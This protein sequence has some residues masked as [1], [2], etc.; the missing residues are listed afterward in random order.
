[1]IFWLYSFFLLQSVDLI[2]LYFAVRYQV[3][4][5]TPKCNNVKNGKIVQVT[6]ACR[7]VLNCIS[8]Q[9]V[10]FWITKR[11]R[12]MKRGCV[13]YLVWSCFMTF[14]FSIDIKYVIQLQ[15]L[16]EFCCM[17]E[18]DHALFIACL[19]RYMFRFF[20][21]CFYSLLIES[22]HPNSP[23]PNFERNG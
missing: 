19:K 23:I 9:C 22:H 10:V 18:I 14:L 1:M 21:C 17:C 20:M 13:S 6:I 4:Q 11:V 5:I 8:F 12:N 2:L 15:A 16:R 7:A 3:F